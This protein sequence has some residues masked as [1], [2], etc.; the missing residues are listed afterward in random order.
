MH[1]PGSTWSLYRDALALRKSLALGDGALTWIEDASEDVVAF[2]NGDVTVLTN[3]SG[4]PVALPAGEVLLSSVD[5]DG[6]LPT[7]AT[8][9]IKRV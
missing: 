1:V 4:A 3:V 6:N 7:D 5:V 2:T 8:V 9:W